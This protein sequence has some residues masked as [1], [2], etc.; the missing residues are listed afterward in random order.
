MEICRGTS[1]LAW[2]SRLLLVL[3]LFITPGSASSQNASGNWLPAINGQ[4]PAGAVAGGAEPGRT[5]YICRGWHQG[6]LHP[7][8][9]VEGRC[10]IGY[11]GNEFALTSFELLVNTNLLWIPY[12]GVIPPGALVGGQENDRVL[13]VCRA[14]HSGGVHPGKVIAGNCNIGFGGQELSIPVFE[15]ALV[16]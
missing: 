10:N 1:G 13:Y 14:A 11:G 5:L 8:K 16:R 15:I 9:V 7:G 3:G 2:C 12:P 6:G 4:I